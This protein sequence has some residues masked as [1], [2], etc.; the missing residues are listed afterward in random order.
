[1]PK[2]KNFVTSAKIIR[3]IGETSKRLADKQ[4][5]RIQWR[6]LHQAYNEFVLSA[7]FVFWLRSIE[8]TAGYLP[9]R[10]WKSIRDEYPVFLDDNLPYLEKHGDAQVWKR[11]EDWIFQNIFRDALCEGWMDAVVYYAVPDLRYLRALA[12]YGQ[13]KIEWKR[14]RP[15][16]HP[17]FRQWRRAAFKSCELPDLRPR[18]LQILR[19][20]SKI[21]A[22][23]VTDAVECYVDWQEFAFWAATGVEGLPDI[24]QSVREQLRRRCPGFL[25]YD[26][27]LRRTDSPD[28]RHSLSRLLD[29]IITHFFRDAKREGWFTAIDYYAR[30]H[31]HWIRMMQY[32]SRWEHQWDH[33]RIKIYP[34]FEEWRRA[35][36]NCVDE[37]PDQKD[38][39]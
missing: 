34:S 25:E 12:Y 28:E 27:P 6:L 15:R 38:D 8:E 2:K 36:D 26:A 39:G 30:L 5:K 3:D 1:M 37:G 29:W 17:S 32:A 22:E 10:V 4:A 14:N 33:G 19:S 13:C 9:D 21:D 24:P 11:L 7:C 35:V 18:L 20:A 23:R 31:P 16:S